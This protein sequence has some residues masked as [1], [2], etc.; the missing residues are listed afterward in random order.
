MRVQVAAIEAE[1][2]RA[3][4]DAEAAAAAAATAAAAAANAFQAQVSSVAAVFIRRLGVAA[5]DCVHL[6]CVDCSGHGA[7]ASSG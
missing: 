6:C 1:K 3:A 2:R 5:T 7:G 4:A